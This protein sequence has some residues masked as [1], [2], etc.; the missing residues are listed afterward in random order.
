MSDFGDLHV[1]T[2][3]C[4]ESY[5]R[6]ATYTNPQIYQIKGANAVTGQSQCFRGW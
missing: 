3:V 4:A 2:T 1:T 5:E 6:V